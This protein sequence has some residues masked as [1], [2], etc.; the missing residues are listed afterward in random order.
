MKHVNWRRFSGICRT[1][2]DRSR[3]D[4]YGKL[5]EEMLRS[6]WTYRAVAR[7]LAE[8]CNVH[9]SISTIHHFVHQRLKAK[10]SSR[11]RRQ[12]AVVTAA[13]V[14][15]PTEPEAGSIRHAAEKEA[16]ADAVYQRI[17]ALKQRTEPVG[18]PANLFHYDPDKPLQLSPK[19]QSQPKQRNEPEPR[20]SSIA[21]WLRTKTGFFAPIPCVLLYNSCQI[22]NFPFGSGG[23]PSSGGCGFGCYSC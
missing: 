8:K 20:S 6:G 12:P 18:N 4:R 7:I 22:E 1:K 15:Q 21:S 10:K 2:P 3:L 5:I 23:W 11:K 16:A 9:A 17:A 14:N 13:A 19:A